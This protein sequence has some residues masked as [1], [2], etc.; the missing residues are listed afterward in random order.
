MPRAGIT[1]PEVLLR[2]MKDHQ[3]HRRFLPSID[4]NSSLM[5]VTKTLLWRF[6]VVFIGLSPRSR[7]AAYIGLYG[8]DYYGYGH[9]GLEQGRSN[10]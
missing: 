2:L 5:V 7:E 9:Q 3:A 10:R 6:I 1:A 8:R 4:R